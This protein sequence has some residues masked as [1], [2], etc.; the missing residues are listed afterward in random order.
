MKLAAG[1]HAIKIMI[2]VA[3]EYCRLVLYAGI[4]RV[5]WP[6]RHDAMQ[7]GQLCLI[8]RFAKGEWDKETVID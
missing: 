3:I 5:D 6:E 2:A 8:A 4:L 1:R 7:V